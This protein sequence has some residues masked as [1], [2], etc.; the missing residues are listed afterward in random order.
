MNMKRLLI[1]ILLLLS[2]SVL[3]GATRYVHPGATG[4]STPSDTDYDAGTGTCGGGSSTVYNTITNGIN[5]LAAS[6]TLIIRNGTYI[7]NITAVPPSGTLA[8][9]THLQ[10]ESRT[11]TIIKPASGRPINWSVAAGSTRTHIKLSLMTLDGSQNI[12]RL[13]VTNNG[14]F[15]NITLEDMDFK[16]ATSG[17]DP[18][19]DDVAITGVGTTD[20]TALGDWIVRRIRVWNAGTGIYYQLPRG[21]VEDSEFWNISRNA[22]LIQ[23]NGFNQPDVHIVRRNVCRESGH[24]AITNEV[25]RCISIIQES[26]VYQNIVYG[27]SDWGILAYGSSA[28][29]SKIFNNTLYNNGF[30]TQTTAGGI[31]VASNTSG[32]SVINNIVLNSSGNALDLNGA[33]MTTATNLTSGTAADIFQSLTTNFCLKPGASTAIDSGTAIA[34][35]AYNGSAPDIGACETFSHSSGTVTGNTMDITYQM[36]LQVPLSAAVNTRQGA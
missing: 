1:A 27:N 21:V 18:S 3:H 24:D 16:D 33:S 19:G 11:G 20:G 25:N 36:N 7:E 4:C 9:P 13:L 12:V 8:A 10:G 5:G 35:Y 17:D 14:R 23:T 29:N 34:G 6:D 31:F 32:I 28:S 22:I 15:G 30:A 26:L 2:P